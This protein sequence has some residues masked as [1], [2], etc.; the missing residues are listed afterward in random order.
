MQSHLPKEDSVSLKVS[1]QDLPLDAST[2][3]SDRL[4]NKHWHSYLMAKKIRSL[5]QMR[6]LTQQQLADHVGVN[7]AAIRNYESQK[8]SPKLKHI[9]KMAEA[10]GVRPEA[11]RLYDMGAGDSI[12]A[13]A[14]FQIAETY[15]LEPEACPDYACLKPQNE[16]MRSALKEWAAQYE[17]FK[18]DAISEQDYQLWKDCYFADYDALAYPKRYKI[19]FEDDPALINNWEA[20]CLAEKLKQ[21]RASYDMTQSDFADLLNIKLGV[22]RSYEQ[23][24]RLPKASVIELIAT[25]LNITLGC[26]TFFDFGSPAQAVHA[27]FQLASEFGL[28]PDIVDGQ[29][30]LRTQT[31]GLEQIIDQWHAALTNADDDEAKFAHWHDRYEPDAPEYRLHHKTRY[32]ESATIEGAPITCFSKLDPYNPK[33]RHGYLPA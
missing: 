10:L 4:S 3:N 21:L 26:L 13:N 31:P 2:L 28:R 29:A 22:Y 20:H 30:I 19:D 7:E 24:W 16:Y 8:A 6:G 1:V 11:L 12:T 32:T 25:K 14:L 33:Y 15:G 5:R 17:Q 18:N 9:E 27:L 23:G